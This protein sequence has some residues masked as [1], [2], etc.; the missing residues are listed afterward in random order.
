MAATWLPKT[1][2][3]SHSAAARPLASGS[4]AGVP[5]IVAVTLAGVAAPDLRRSEV[6]FQK[7]SRSLAVKA[8]LPALVYCSLPR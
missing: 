2:S 3:K 4:S 1:L 6:K 5:V 7:S 8:I